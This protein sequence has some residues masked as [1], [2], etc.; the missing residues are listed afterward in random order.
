MA[1]I[2]SLRLARL[3]VGMNSPRYAP[4]GLPVECGNARVMIDDGPGAAPKWR[5]AAWLVTDERVGLAQRHALAH[6]PL[7]PIQFATPLF[8]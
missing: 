6:S 8:A 4:A 1:R 2:N 7:S 3:G 5:I